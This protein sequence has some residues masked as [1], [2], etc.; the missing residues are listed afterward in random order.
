MLLYVVILKN[1]MKKLFW[2][3]HSNTVSNIILSYWFFIFS[4]TLGFAEFRIFRDNRDRE[5]V[6]ELVDYEDGVVSLRSK[7]GKV[8]TVPFEKLSP[9]D[10][11][12]CSQSKESLSEK[13]VDP[14]KKDGLDTEQ[15]DKK[16]SQSPIQAKISSIDIKPRANDNFSVASFHLSIPKPER[17][18]RYIL[19]LAPGFNQDGSKLINQKVWLDFANETGGAIMACTFK[20]T[21]QQVHHY[22][23]ARHGSGNALESAIEKLDRKF[24]EHSLKNLP[25]LV[26]GFS[27]GGQFAYGLSCHIPK[28]MLGFV[29][30]KG[31]YYF[32][33]TIRQT[34]RVPG[35]V[36]SGI[37]D[38]ERRRMAIRKLFESHRS[39][40]APWC[41]M[42]D[43]TGH[44][45][46]NTLSVVLPFFQ[47]LIKM[48]LG[49]Q[50]SLMVDRS[51]L[52]G[53]LVNLPTKT[54]LEES[55][56]FDGRARDKRQGWLPSKKVFD[57]W[58][59]QDVGNLK[60]KK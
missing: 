57:L 38:L 17:T 32:P 15:S 6:A 12:F 54:V 42:E 50:G 8:Y 47:E 4:S 41:W 3:Y 1:K 55:K 35:L 52:S 25:L 59:S 26:Y 34:Y 60:Y 43:Q 5:V 10:Q 39:K 13:S 53:I 11:E 16:L 58:S 45:P 51:K 21:K 18:A 27:A 33:E 29:A 20:M 36:I 46:G 44:K 31:G 19:V 24:P 49:E 56:P 23:A 2:V 40:G 48:Q 14:K 30:S 9:S 28:R 37:E 7:N 22:A